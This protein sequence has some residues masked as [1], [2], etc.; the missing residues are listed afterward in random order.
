MENRL[1]IIE[2]HVAENVGMTPDQLVIDAPGHVIEIEVAPLIGQL[3]MEDHLQQDI[4]QFLA[5]VLH[6]IAVNGVQQLAGLVDER[7]TQGLVGLLAVPGASIRSPQ[8]GHG[9]S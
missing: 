9:L 4:A 1:G 8:A 5:H 6:I 2:I 7:L 3:G